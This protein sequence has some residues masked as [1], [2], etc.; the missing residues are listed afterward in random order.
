[1]FESAS[2]ISAAV[3]GRGVTPLSAPSDKPWRWRSFSV[4]DPSG[5]V[6]DFFHVLAG[7]DTSLAGEAGVWAFAAAQ[8][9]DQEGEEGLFYTWTA[10][11]IREILA[12]DADAF[13]RAYDVRPGGNWEGRNVLRRVGPPGDPAS[14]KVLARARE[15]L[16]ARRE[17]REK[18]ARDD[19]ILVDWNGLMIRAL[20]RASIVFDEPDWLDSAQHAWRIVNATARYDGRLAHAWR[21]RATAVGQLDDYAAFALA[22]LALYEA[23]G[24]GRYLDEA[25]AL[26]K[27]ALDLFGADD[28]S[29]FQ[30]ARDAEDVPVTRPRNVRDNATP[31]G[32]GMAADLFARLHHLTGKP[33][34]R[35]A[36][37]NLVRAFSGAGSALALSPTLLAAADLLERAKTV[38]V[39]GT[40]EQGADALLH[41]ALASPDPA[42]CV[43]RADE[44]APEGS[45]ARD[46]NPVDGKAAAY[47][48][49]D[50]VCGLPTTD[51]D[52]LA[53]ELA[54]G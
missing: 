33:R 15:I 30:T 5:V 37:E 29:L 24:K 44:F 52:T 2:E 40:A 7:F 4:S 42:V 9:A 17:M 3:S 38:V 47:V 23:T 25:K 26:A 18:P 48:C 28:G 13:M 31:A 10:E 14:E 12:A 1:M 11:E 39:A 50:L 45:P 46:R 34:W 54:N 21:A 51:A 6:L 20:A 43:L 36:C 19:K 53:R 41:R 32:A 35:D 16:F 22:A 8:D 49:R 27:E